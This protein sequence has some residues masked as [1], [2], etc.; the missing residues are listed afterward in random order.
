MY[1]LLVLCEYFAPENLIAAIRPTKLAK[2]L[3]LSG[4]FDVTVVCKKQRTKVI[5]TVLLDDTKYINK[6]VYIE[7][8]RFVKFILDNFDHLLNI[9][10][11]SLENSKPSLVNINERAGRLSFKR[12]VF[13]YIKEKIKILN[14]KD[15]ASV[16]YKAIKRELNYDFVFTTYGPMGA[17]YLVKKI[18]EKKPEIKWIADFRDQVVSPFA[19]KSVVK[20]GEKILKYTA[21]KADYVTAVSQGVIDSL[22]LPENKQSEVITNGYD[23]NDFEKMSDKVSDRNDKFTL[24]YT[25]ALYR[26]RRDLTV[27]FKLFRELA[28]EGLIEL[29]KVRI[30]YAGDG[31]EVLL[32]QAEPFG[33]EKIIEDN[34]FVERKEALQLQMSCDIL[35]LA[36]W[37]TSGNTGIV[38]GK[39]L[40]YMMMDK[41]IIC[42][43][44]GE[45]PNSKL[46]EMIT[47]A[48]NGIC[49][50]QAADEKDY[51]RLKDYILKQYNLWKE[52]L[53]LEYRPNKEYIS[54]FNYS[55]ISQRVSNIFINLKAG[56]K[57]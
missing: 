38:T 16:A 46:K 13:D 55:N 35:L 7:N 3:S 12:K 52:G 40:E 24:T 28:E 42:L 43:I 17:N 8:S 51:V 31:L 30:V 2:Y 22:I 45:I 34:G 15:F 14:S 44:C 5:D 36:S 21:L 53:E 23:I 49:Y 25:G 33:L 9:Y 57:K 56:F 39:F 26:G 4:E 1:K 20:E 10:S 11:K 6:I 27:L 29:E 54:Q 19:I 32:G 47:L 48:E 50:E 41:P 18:K 37:N